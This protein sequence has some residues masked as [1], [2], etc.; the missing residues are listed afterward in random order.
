MPKFKP[1][2]FKAFESMLQSFK[3]SGYLWG[4]PGKALGSNRFT[5]QAPE[6]GKVY[7]RILNEADQIVTLTTAVNLGANLDPAI[8]VRMEYIEGQLTII[9]PH[10][11]DAARA[12]GNK[13]SQSAVPPHSG[14]IGGGID[15]YIDSQRFTPGL[16]TASPVGGMFVRVYAFRY[17]NVYIPTQDYEI[18]SGSIPTNPAETVLTEIVYNPTSGLIESYDGSVSTDSTTTYDQDDISAITIP[19]EVVPLGAIT[20][21]N[22]MTTTLAAQVRVLDAREFLNDTYA[23]PDFGAT[24]TITLAA[25]VLDL[26][27]VVARNI[28]VASESGT[29]DNL[30]QILGLNVGQEVTLSADSGDTITLINSSDVI[31]YSGADFALSGSSLLKLV[32]VGGNVVG[33][34]VDQTGGTSG[35]GSSLTVQDST[36]TPS[37]ANIST[38]EFVGG[39]L[40]NP[41]TNVARY[42]PPSGGG[43]GSASL[44][45]DY[46]NN[47]VG[48]NG[49]SVTVS[50]TLDI[51]ANQNFTV[52]SGGS[53]I[54]EFSMRGV[55]LA[56][57]SGSQVGAQLVIDSGGTPSVV[58]IGGCTPNSSFPNALSGSAPVKISGLSVGSHTVKLQILNAAGATIAVYCRSLA[59]QSEFV[60]LQVTQFT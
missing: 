5:F 43:G 30:I 51:F 17:G 1:E 42:T 4:L 53:G 13:V 59:S 14:A 22:G 29:S 24:E 31:L 6:D 26:S 18:P 23:Y 35:Y 37:Y 10:P 49:T 50:S 15:D 9:N 33:N 20:L 39:T 32:S 7:V 47:S 52:A 41:S 54:V 34:Y 48:I 40:T 2:T 19:D 16:V 36:G 45:L 12:Y 38:L 3:R 57:S 56:N 60:G 46:T 21:Y 28:I 55:V 11:A 44:L 58:P 27:N 8:K 25:G